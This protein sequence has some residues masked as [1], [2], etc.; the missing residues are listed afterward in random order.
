MRVTGHAQK[1]SS[2]VP[3][4]GLGISRLALS[5]PPL[6]DSRKREVPQSM[7]LGHHGVCLV[8]VPVEPDQ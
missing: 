4:L 6:E 1:I 2:G 7:G 3:E 8:C 5:Y